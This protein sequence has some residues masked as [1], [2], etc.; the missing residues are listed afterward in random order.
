MGSGKGKPF[1]WVSAV[2]YGSVIFEIGFGFSREKTLK[3]FREVSGKLGIK[4]RV[5]VF[6]N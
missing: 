4:T 1:S 3:I 6:F 2:A 5:C